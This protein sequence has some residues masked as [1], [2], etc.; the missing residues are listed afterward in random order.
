MKLPMPLEDRLLVG[1]RC[2]E[3]VDLLDQAHAC[4]WSAKA[5]SRWLPQL[6]D[7]WECFLATGLMRRR[8]R[9]WQLTD[10]LGMAVSNMVL[11]ELVEWWEEV[12]ADAD[13]P[14]SCARP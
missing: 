5:C 13:H 8:G 11:V 4:G 12:S 3:G 1:L 6:E 10:P 9:R 7:R 14:A 2:R